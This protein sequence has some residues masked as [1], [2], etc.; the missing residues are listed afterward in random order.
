MNERAFRFDLFIAVAALV[1]SAVA[2]FAAV[3]QT[4]AIQD[5]Y[6]A[7]IWPYLNVDDTADV[8][9]GTDARSGSVEAI[10]LSLTNNGLGPAL[11]RGATL[12]IDG[13]PAASWR[14]LLMTLTHDS[15][16]T[17]REAASAHVPIRMSSLDSS[18]T[19]R[20]GDTHRIFEARL[21]KPVPMT[22][23]VKHDVT[24]DV[25]YCSLND[26]CWSVR[27]AMTRTTN[28]IPQPTAH[29]DATAHIDS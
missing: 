1:L 20:P 5:Q 24:L 15:G 16:V 22:T 21:I 2:A 17:K 23:I 6:A 11:I 27:A 28:S 8:R 12:T 26:R 19:I 13:H 29:C 4:R 25:C 7:T 3:Y 9:S 10:Q 18:T 14:N